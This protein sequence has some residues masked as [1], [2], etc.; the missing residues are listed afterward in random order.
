MRRDLGE[1]YWRTLPEV[2]RNIPLTFVNC[3]PIAIIGVPGGGNDL[4]FVLD[5][6]EERFVGTVHTAQTVNEIKALIASSSTRT[7]NVNGRLAQKL[8]TGSSGERFRLFIGTVAAN[9]F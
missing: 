5:T 9:G 4:S 6:G 3:L 1:Y 2:A 8:D 7:L